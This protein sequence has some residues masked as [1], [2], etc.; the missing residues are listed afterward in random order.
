MQDIPAGKYY[1][2]FR[3]DSALHLRPVAHFFT[4]NSIFSFQ[5]FAT[6]KQENKRCVLPLYSLALYV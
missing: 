1:T 2:S 6:Q 5:S 4:P 3:Y